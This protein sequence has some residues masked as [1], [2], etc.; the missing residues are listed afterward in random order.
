MEKLSINILCSLVVSTVFGLTA[1]AQSSCLDGIRFRPENVRIVTVPD[2]IGGVGRNLELSFTLDAE[3]LPVIKSQNSVTLVPVFE[4]GDGSKT[5]SFPPIYIDGR[6]RAK[7][8]DRMAVLS[9][10]DRPEGSIVLRPG[11]QKGTEDIEYRARIP[12]DSA[13]LGGKLVLYETISGCAGCTEDGDSLEYC[14]LLPPYSPHWEFSASPASGKKHGEIRETADIKFIVNKYDI[15][16]DWQDNRDVLEKIMTSLRT[17]SDTAMFTVTS[18]KFTGYASPDGP[19]NFNMELAR[20][21]VESLVEYV[22]NAD[23][24]I[25]DSVFSIGSISEN[26]EGLFAAVDSDPEISGN[27]IIREIRDSLSEDNWQASEKKLKSDKKLYDYLR[28]NILPSLRRTEYTIE[29]EIRNFTAQ[30]AKSLW[31]TR[32][33]VLSVDEFMAAAML[34]GKDSPEYLQVLL[35]AAETYPDNVSALNNAAI[36]LYDSKMF[37]EAE[38]LLEGTQDPLLLNTL[39]IIQASEK[40]YEKASESFNRSLAGKNTEA[41]Y[42][43]KELEK[44]LY[45]L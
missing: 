33:D 41:A 6:I 13:M 34:Y 30:E 25:P 24:R 29:Y 27:S 44:I 1:T 7:A 2:N 38:T 15:M 22:K 9:G 37:T 23:E 5:F 40:S 21:R 12:Y 36:A 35:K 10:I 14:G 28:E 31:D 16:P 26:W 42:N 17:A 20:R 11:A 43:L 18:V 45:Q 8:I 39:G 32:P 19:E 3:S 4:T